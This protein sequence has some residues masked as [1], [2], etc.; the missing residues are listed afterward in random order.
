MSSS[1]HPLRFVEIPDHS[2]RVNVP[3]TRD[4]TETINS[5]TDEIQLVTSLKGS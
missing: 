3:A 2:Q 5:A 1:Q 4:L